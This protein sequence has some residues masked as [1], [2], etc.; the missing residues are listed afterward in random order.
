MDSLQLLFY[1]A[2]LSATLLVFVIPFFEPVFGDH[3]VFSAWSIEAI[4]SSSTIN[5]AELLHLSYFQV[6]FLKGTNQG[7]QVIVLLTNTTKPVLTDTQKSLYSRHYRY[8]KSGMTSQL[9]VH[10]TNLVICN[11]FNVTRTCT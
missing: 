3:G 5:C 10:K 6:V 8:R 7:Y 9:F 1:Q 11:G 4:V 2:P